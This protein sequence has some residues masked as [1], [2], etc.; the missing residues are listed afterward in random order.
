MSWLDNVPENVRMRLCDC[1][2]TKSDVSVLAKAKWM[3]LR[4]NDYYCPEDAFVEVLELLDCNG[5]DNEL[6][7]DEYNDILAELKVSV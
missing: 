5:F 1:K 6:T 2:S 7:I 4:K 3:Q